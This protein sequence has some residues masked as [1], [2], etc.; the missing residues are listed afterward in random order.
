MIQYFRKGLKPSI[1]TWLDARGRELDS[2]K[3]AVEKPINIEAKILLQSAS[4]TCKIDL[5]C[6]QGNKSAKKEEED[7]G[8]TKSTNTSPI[9]VSSGKH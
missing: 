1:W 3:E 7:P 9:D 4:Y 8:K 5:R 2:W 6:S